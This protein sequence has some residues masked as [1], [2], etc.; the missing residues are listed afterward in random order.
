MF[1]VKYKHGATIVEANDLEHARWIVQHH[2][3]SES[4][5][6]IW[7]PGAHFDGWVIQPLDDDES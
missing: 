3:D 1:V 4:L 7:A 5:N 2:I 6:I